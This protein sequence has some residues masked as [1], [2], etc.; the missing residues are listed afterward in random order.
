MNITKRLSQRPALLLLAGAAFIAVLCYVLIFHQGSGQASR[1]GP[2]ISRDGLNIEFS[3]N[4][5]TSPDGPVMAGEIARLSLKFTDAGTGRPVSGL[6]PAGWIDPL[7]EGAEDINSETC[8]ASAGTY[9]AG[10]VGIRPMIDLNSY[11]LVVLNSDPTIAVVDPIIGVRGITKLLTQVILPGRGEDWARS[12]D[13]K[14]VFVAMPGLGSVASVD[15]ETF[16][17]AETVAVG[18]SP[19]RIM[20]QPDGRYVWV[21]TTGEGSGVTIIDSETMKVAARIPTGAGHHELLVTADNRHAFVTN[22]DDRTVSIID[23]RRLRKTGDLTL[24][25]RPI[26]LAY[27]ELAQ[28]V[29]IADAE[30][31][32]IIVTDS[33]GGKV[34]ATIALEPGLGPMRVA[35]GGRFLLAVNPAV[36]A[37]FVVDTANNQLV[38]RLTI[39]GEP[40][41][42][43][44]SRSFAFVRS[45]S[46]ATVSMIRLADLGGRDQV[47]INRFEA[48][49]RPP[50]DSPT[51]LPSDL[52]ATAVTEAATMVVSPGDANVY[53]YM[54]GMNAPMGSFGGYGHRPLSAIVVDRTIK[55]TAPGEYVSTVKIPASGNFHLI[56]T[57]DSPQMIEC[58][59]FTAVP[60]PHLARDEAP[61]RIAYET[62]SGA[63]APAGQPVKVRFTLSDTA[64]GGEPYARDD[65]LVVT[66]RAPG[67]DRTE[68]KAR[69][70]SDGVFEVAF[71]PA[72]SGAY[73]VYPSVRSVGLDYGKLPF[74]T[75]VAQEVERI[76]GVQ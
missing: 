51:L 65:V 25:G 45:L 62:R 15:L 68:H 46:T 71:T 49:E 24:R 31:G 57:M 12:A 16:R 70:I 74:L 44:F 10:Y 64:A 9:L 72:E 11:Y 75:I 42:I 26:S 22:R 69:R 35:P 13:E 18:E 66:F 47:T 8:R 6:L 56:M 19:T 21:G 50:A 52:F 5:V 61:L 38:H 58:F 34:R 27:S 53:Y 59:A 60:N 4:P 17:L 39:P 23:V 33:D 55:E 37:V 32:E 29:Y 73:Y 48:G 2:V 3:I 40:F 76:G 28:A 30:T 7:R 43:S 67:Q 54:E 14:R 41:Q 63:L 36:N 1:G 20:V